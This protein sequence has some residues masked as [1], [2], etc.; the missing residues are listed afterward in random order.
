MAGEELHGRG[1]TGRRDF[2]FPAVTWFGVPFFRPQKTI[3]MVLVA[4]RSA[5][6]AVAV[7]PIKTSHFKSTSCLANKSTIL[8]FSLKNRS[9][10]MRLPS[11]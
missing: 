11:A 2:G 6:A 7:T 4:L 8:K 5:K 1:K 10:K 9:S 3:G